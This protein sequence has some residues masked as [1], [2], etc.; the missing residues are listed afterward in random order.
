MMRRFLLLCAALPLAASAQLQLFVFDGTAEKVVSGVTDYGAVATGDTRELRFRVRNNTNT[1]IA[2]QPTRTATLAGE[3]FT[4][5]SAPSLPFVIAPTN[6]TEI[7]IRF[8]GS[9]VATYSATFM[10]NQVQCL[11]RASVV[12]AASI[13]QPGSGTL[14]T[15]STIDFGRVQKGQSATRDLQLSNVTTVPLT[16]Q[17]CAISGNV[18]HSAALRCPP[19]F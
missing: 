18:F 4:I 8:G 13:S 19:C 12:A 9:L 5:S 16:I 7:R 10:V 11:L 1:A 17:A 6:F 3:G 15:G 14:T 2:L